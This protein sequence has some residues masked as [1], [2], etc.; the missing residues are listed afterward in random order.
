[1][2][3]FPMSPGSES[4]SFLLP[5]SLPFARALASPHFTRSGIRSRSSWLSTGDLA[6]ENFS[7]I[8]AAERPCASDGNQ[9]ER[10]RTCF[11][12]R[13]NSAHPG[14]AP[15]AEVHLN[16]FFSDIVEIVLANPTFTDHLAS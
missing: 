7:A 4:R 6:E 10:L 16:A 8:W 13:N 1:M 11:Q 9:A 15:I 5:M 12:W 14:H 3:D 2:A